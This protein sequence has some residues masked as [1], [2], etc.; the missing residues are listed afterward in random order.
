MP[1]TFASTYDL[2]RQMRGEGS[3]PDEWSLPQFSRFANDM[4]GTNEFQEGERNPIGAVVSKGSY[5]VDQALKSTGIPEAAGRGGAR[6]FEALGGSPEVGQQVG[7]AAPRGVLDMASFF[8]PGLGPANSLARLGIAGAMGAAHSY[9]DTGQTL[10][11]VAA[12]ASPFLMTAGGN[13]VAGLAEKAGL[14][15]PVTHIVGEEL[16]KAGQGTGNL[17]SQA[18]LESRPDRLAHFAAHQIGALGTAEATNYATAAIQNKTWT[19][20]EGES[21][22]DKVLETTVGNFPYMLGGV[23]DVVSG[24]PQPVGEHQIIYKPKPEEAPQIDPAQVQAIQARAALIN[25]EGRAQIMK[26]LARP[27]SPERNQAVA[28]A[29]DALAQNLKTNEGYDQFDAFTRRLPTVEEFNR[30]FGT[31]SEPV[32]KA[33]ELAQAV[34][35]NPDIDPR[36]LDAWAAVPPLTVDQVKTPIDLTKVHNDTQRIIEATTP[37][38]EPEPVVAGQAPEPVTPPQPQIRVQP[39]SLDT[40]VTHLTN[41]G[42]PPNEAVIAAKVGERNVVRNAAE[43]LTSSKYRKPTAQIQDFE[44][45]GGFVPPEKGKGQKDN[46]KMNEGKKKK[47]E[48]KKIPEAQNNFA[49]VSAANLNDT[50][51]H[52][53]PVIDKTLKDSV[54][55]VKRLISKSPKSEAIYSQWDNWRQQLIDPSKRGGSWLTGKEAR[56]PLEVLRGM[57]SSR[58]IREQQKEVQRG[59]V[60]PMKKSKDPDIAV[61]QSAYDDILAQLQVDH[62]LTDEQIVTLRKQ[63]EGSDAEKMEAAKTLLRLKESGQYEAPEPVSNEVALPKQTGSLEDEQQLGEQAVERGVNADQMGADEAPPVDEESQGLHVDVDSLLGG[64][65]EPSADEL[66]AAGGNK[67]SGQP[68]VQFGTGQVIPHILRK[69]GFSEPEIGV[70]SKWLNR[71]GNLFNINKVTFAELIND[72]KRWFGAGAAANN[73]RMVFLAKGEYGASDVSAIHMGATLAHELGHIIDG[74]AQ[75]GLL[76]ERFN[77]AIS[78]FKNFIASDPQA[79]LDMLKMMHE[80]LPEQ[81]R[82]NPVWL[83][84][85]N[86]ANPNEIYANIMSAWALGRIDG[87]NGLALGLLAP[88]QGKNFLQKMGEYARRVFG[89]IKGFFTMSPGSRSE[90]LKDAVDNITKQFD[91][92]NK[93]MQEADFRMKD[94]HTVATIGSSDSWVMRTSEMNAGFQPAEYGQKELRELANIPYTATKETGKVEDIWN[95]LIRDQHYIGMTIP[96]FRNA[97]SLLLDHAPA[98]TMFRNQ[99]LAPLVGGM[100][101]DTGTISA[102]GKA[103]Q[104]YRRLDARVDAKLNGVASEILQW[105]QQPGVGDKAFVKNADG[106][107][108]NNV[109][110][111]LKDTNPIWP[112]GAKTTYRLADAYNKLDQRSRQDIMDHIARSTESN[113]V[114]YTSTIDSIMEHRLGQLKI[115]FGTTTPDRFS[116]ADSV[117]R[118]FTAAV[119]KANSQDPNVR[120]QGAREL[121]VSRQRIGDDQKYLKM[122]DMWMS[123]KQDASDMQGSFRPEH[124]STMRRGKYLVRAI[125]ESKDGAGKLHINHYSDVI[126]D[127]GKEYEAWKANRRAEGFTKFQEPVETQAMRFAASPSDEM[128]NTLAMID[129]RNKERINLLTDIPEDIKQVMLKGTDTLGEFAR[130]V[131]AGDIST[132]AGYNNL[133]PQGGRKATP[134]SMDMIQTQRLALGVIA[135]L[136]ATKRMS[137]H[138]AYE[139]LNPELKRFPSELKQIKGA[140]DAYMRPDSPLGAALAKFNAVYY[141]GGNLPTHLLNLAQSWNTTLAEGVNRGLSPVKSLVEITKAAKDVSKFTLD[142][143][144]TNLGLDKDHLAVVKM[145]DAEERELFKWSIANGLW[146]FGHLGELHDNTADA[147]SDINRIGNTGSNKKWY[148]AV[149]TPINAWADFTMKAFGATEHFNQRVATLAGFRIARR[150]MGANYDR[151]KAFEFAKDFMRS[152]TYSG[153]RANRPLAQSQLGAAGN[154]AYSLQTY[155]RGWLNQLT[156]YLVHWKGAEYLDLSPQQRANARRASLTMLGIQMASAGALGMP[157]VGAG[158]KILEK[159]TG[160]ALTA[161]L[162]QS[163]GQMLDDDSQDGG[164]LANVILNGGANAMLA[165]AGLPVDIG[166]RM[167]VGGLFGLNANDGF[168]GDAVFGP[169]GQ[170]VASVVSGL[171]S[172]VGGDLAA[173]GNALAPPALKKAIA[174]WR[175]GGEIETSSGKLVDSSGFEKAAYA[176]GFSPQS[177]SNLNQYLS[178]R[179]SVEAQ[180]EI[181]HK[182]EA[183]GILQALQ[184][185]NPDDAQRMLVETAQKTGRSP[186][187]LAKQVAQTAADQAFPADVR[188]GL[189]Q[190]TGPGLMQTAR[191]IGVQVPVAHEVAK[192]TYMNNMLELLGVPPMRVNP[193]LEQRDQF[194]EEYAPM[195]SV[196]RPRRGA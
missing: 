69:T 133:L 155:T 115:Y 167:Q 120:F 153:G 17:V 39:D 46:T 157:F 148:D 112:P 32:D 123:A 126:N 68:T 165:N 119:D 3:I 118:Q 73:L 110:K 183:A 127:T 152:S 103:Y 60:D 85:L 44:N 171:K 27:E 166:S 19:P 179:K 43:L 77:K 136:N 11:T 186:Q 102:R 9:A 131:N 34:G 144:K 149:K 37:K 20:Y 78:D 8:V 96:Q 82:D 170:L 28:E 7:E 84:R 178:Y 158:L 53:D 92:L 24:K 117:V 65:E 113:R 15:N 89:A 176:V 150:Q 146:S 172:T 35:N 70:L 47:Y 141:L 142:L 25:T 108:T 12:A 94:L 67:A 130:I 109:E 30:K 63:L 174:L 140:L 54:P 13:A 184:E 23:K 145:K 6:A 194:G 50:P 101:K 160:K 81:F 41:A 36:L 52:S 193:L 45:E 156:R 14:I 97:T 59:V 188:E 62:N 114:T 195:S 154:M 168:S 21:L 2:Y 128:I 76:P 49:A 135:R 71:I 80:Q 61:T 99:Y 86:N 185:N 138:L 162:Y 147:A 192:Q 106:S 164:G 64:D 187:E 56:D 181:Q 33:V 100:N 93:V 55:M 22:Y 143:L 139:L 122:L 129:V 16:T 5:W 111:L 1:Q 66:L 38:A 180:L 79:G 31:T 42:T 132:P 57:L 90:F 137:T 190:E 163:L 151:Q 40:V 58:I 104:S 48:E 51:A 121:E 29:K 105:L 161:N 107:Y 189:N 75:K 175:N 83:D 74:M 159:V 134:G 196:H 116:Q 191:A 72:D 87:E 91:G 98:Q 88:P 182:Q 95:N 125:S 18:F 177:V 173:A 4:T 124:Q 169:T 10:P 26:L